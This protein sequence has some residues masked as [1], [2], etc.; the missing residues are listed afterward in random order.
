M[1]SRRMST[2][3]R[4][5]TRADLAAIVAELPSR[6]EAQHAHRLLGQ[7]QEHGVYLIAWCD[8][9][10]VGHVMVKW[11][12][13]P[14]RH[15]SEFTARYDCSWVEDLSVEALSRNQGIGR[16]LMETL[17]A[18]T[19]ARRLGRVGLDV[20]LDEGYAAARYLYESLDYRDVGHGTYLTSAVVQGGGVWMERLV[21]LLKELT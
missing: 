21:F 15:V 18:M 17:E 13:W 10:P 12:G 3:I 1:A 4:R 2:D 20:G 14:E 11:P 7:E 8:D 9:R 19:R 16:S 5:A 6:T